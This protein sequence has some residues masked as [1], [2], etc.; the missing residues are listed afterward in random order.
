VAQRR[1]NRALAAMVRQLEAFHR[2]GE[3]LSK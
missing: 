2:S 1:S 3:A